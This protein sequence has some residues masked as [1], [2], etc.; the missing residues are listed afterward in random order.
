[1]RLENRL[2]LICRESP[3]LYA[4]PD[5]CESGYKELWSS[6]LL[7]SETLL[8][9]DQKIRVLLQPRKLLLHL[10]SLLERGRRQRLLEYIHFKCGK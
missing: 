9:L 10:R 1:M 8:N 5:L 3:C 2:H 6:V 4:L 7:V